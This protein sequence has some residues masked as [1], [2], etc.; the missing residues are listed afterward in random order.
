M[1]DGLLPPNGL[2]ISSIPDGSRSSLNFFSSSI[3]RYMIGH[4]I[5][6]NDGTL[7]IL[8]QTVVN[9]MRTF[10]CQARP[11]DIAITVEQSM[12]Q[13]VILLNG[14]VLFQ[15][16]CVE[17]TIIRIGQIVKYEN[18]TVSVLGPNT[19]FP[20]ITTFW[21]CDSF[22]CYKFNSSKSF[23]RS[24]PTSKLFTCKQVALYSIAGPINANIEDFLENP[25]VITTSSIP[26]TPSP[27][28]TIV[29]SSFFTI[30]ITPLPSIS[31]SPSV[32]ETTS[33]FTSVPLTT[34]VVFSPTPTS[35]LLPQ[36]PSISSLISTPFEGITPTPTSF[37]IVTL[38]PSALVTPTPTDEAP[39]TTKKPEKTQTKT[40]GKKKC[41]IKTP[42]TKNRDTTRNLFI[43]Y[44]TRTTKCCRTKMIDCKEQ[45]SYDTTRRIST[46]TRGTVTKNKDTR[47]LTAKGPPSRMRSKTRCNRKKKRPRISTNT[48]ERTR[49]SKA[50]VGQLRGSTSRAPTTNTRSRGTATKTRGRGGKKRTKTT[51]TRT[52][53][54]VNTRTRGGTS[55][56]TRRKDNKL[57]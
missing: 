18:S 46:K 14:E 3:D 51:I 1:D 22:R 25:P 40:K 4:N 12:G 55:K 47:T 33:V 24:G 32:L 45:V 21:Y 44:G 50:L 16:E 2:T 49:T 13:N 31:I 27:T 15:L 7:T 56:K 43:D 54:T 39:P 41:I 53:G 28:T 35:Q 34:T 29:S 57:Y 5:T 9:G 8:M 36:T 48:D 26:V 37:P 23:L 6:E 42:V 20:N 38:T 17:T 52:K 19:E 10:S 11:V 30:N